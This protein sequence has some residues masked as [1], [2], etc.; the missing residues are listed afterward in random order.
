[1]DVSDRHLNSM[2]GI[3]KSTIALTGDRP[4]GSLHLGHFVGSLQKRLELQDL[5]SQLIIIADLQGLTSNFHQS[6]KMRDDSVLSM[7]SDYLSVGLDPEK[8]VIFVQSKIE[9]LYPIFFYYLNLV[10]LA[11]LQ[12]NPTIKQEALDKGYHDESMHLG[13]L[14]HPISQAADITAFQADLVPVGEDQKPLIEQTNEIVHKFASIYGSGIIKPVKVLY[15]STP[16]LLGIDGQSKASKSLGNAIF[17]TDD[18][19]TVKEKVYAMY[20]DPNHIRVMDPGK[21]EGNVVFHYLDAF[22]QDGEHLKQLKLDYEKGGLGD[23]TLKALLYET[24]EG[25]LAPIRT[26]RGT[27]TADQI[28]QILVDGNAR[29]SAIANETLGRIRDAIGS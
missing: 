26:R 20:T 28:Q 18:S 13:F 27:I 14:C 19:K 15:G 4:T 16:R 8:N 10:T 9:A 22:Y 29:A 1:M 17:L 5:C 3:T 21:V 6:N 7:V 23:M 11:R 25:F 24:L 2:A 12:R